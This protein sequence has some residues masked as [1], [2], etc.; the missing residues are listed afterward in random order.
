MEDFKNHKHFWLVIHFDALISKDF[1]MGLLRLYVPFFQF[2]PQRHIQNVF[3][4]VHSHP[5]KQLTNVIWGKKQFRKT[6]QLPAWLLSMLAPLTPA[7]PSQPKLICSIL[8]N[9]RCIYSVN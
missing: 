5:L 3:K 2:D 8:H 9:G 6:A 4:D 1:F 7:P